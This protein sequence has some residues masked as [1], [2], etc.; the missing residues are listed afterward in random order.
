MESLN[1]IKLVKYVGMIFC[2]F[3]LLKVSDHDLV[4]WKQSVM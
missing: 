4:C 2:I 3:I 1:T